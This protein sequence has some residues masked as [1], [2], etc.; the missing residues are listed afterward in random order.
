MSKSAEGIV[1]NAV[2]F[3]GRV[4]KT[5]KSWVDLTGTIGPDFVTALYSDGKSQS[6]RP[7]GKLVALK[8]VHDGT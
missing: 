3:T 2:T 4:H 8:E 6:S 7:L 1:E 5:K